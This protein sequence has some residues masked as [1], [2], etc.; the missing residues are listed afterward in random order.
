MIA[1]YGP[2]GKIAGI[3]ILAASVVLGEG[4]QRP[5]VEVTPAVSGKAR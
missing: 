1:N 2:D 4:I 3:E 5:V